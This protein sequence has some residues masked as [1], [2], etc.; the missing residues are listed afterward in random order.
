MADRRRAARITERIREELTLA[1]RT[2]V[3]DPRVLRVIISRVEVPDDL[4]LATVYIRLVPPPQNP[5]G[6]MPAPD[7]PQERLAVKQALAGLTAAAGMLR[8]TISQGL[9]LRYTPNLRFH[10]DASQE[11]TSRVE[12]L[13][14]E[15]ASERKSD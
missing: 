8:R 10:F 3:R 1:L 11:T 7:S 5:D 9:G 4:Q 6:T 15:I 12:S 13:L 2:A 14:R